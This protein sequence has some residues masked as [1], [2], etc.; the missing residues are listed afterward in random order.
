MM[1]WRDI[2]LLI[3]AFLAGIGVGLSIANLIYVMLMTEEK[4]EKE[5]K[6]IEEKH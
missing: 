1:D 6:K 2:L 3:D 4:K 5:E